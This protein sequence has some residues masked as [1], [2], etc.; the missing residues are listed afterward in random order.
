MWLHE[1]LRL[2]H[3]ES[4]IRDYMHKLRA[5]IHDTP[6]DRESINDGRGENSLEELRAVLTTSEGST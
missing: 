4:P 3:N 5:V 6:A 2:V 1:R